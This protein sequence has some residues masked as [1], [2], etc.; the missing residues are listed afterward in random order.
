MLN[1]TTFEYFLKLQF[2]DF[3]NNRG[4][5]NSN[6]NSCSINFMIT[7]IIIFLFTMKHKI[8]YNT[9]NKIRENREQITDNNTEDY[10]KPEH[11]IMQ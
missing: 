9:H 5:S 4:S 2:Y 10:S 3:N 8:S 6:S 1:Y 7:V 11:M